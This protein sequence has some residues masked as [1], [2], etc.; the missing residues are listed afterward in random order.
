MNYIIEASE[1][2]AALILS[3]CHVAEEAGELPKDKQLCTP[4][5]ESPKDSQNGDYASSFALQMAKELRLP[6]RK[7]AEILCSYMDLSGS[8]FSS[9]TF[10]GPG[11]INFRLGP[12]WFSQVLA[13]VFNEGNDYGKSKCE[14]SEKIMVEFVSANPTGPMHMG[15]AR[16]GVLG[17]CL[18]EVLSRAGNQVS[19]E[20]YVND[21]G[22]QIDKFAR[23][24][25][26]RYQ[27]IIL[28]ED[29]VAFPED[30]YF[31]NDI[32]DLARDFYDL[33]GDSFME[34]DQNTRHEAMTT[35]GLERNIKKM[36]SGP[37][38]L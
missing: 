16:G 25:E 33:Y 1:Q 30:G 26:A 11:F 34:K 22:S 17:D 13:A 38:P 15:N 9:C 28:G 36:R 21:T 23:S 10:A 29:A 20:F 24:L 32:K 18:A 8:W 5:I 3:A 4:Q 6:P 27:Q 12:A 19:R 37:Q 2:A 7:I 14:H 31:G 35:F